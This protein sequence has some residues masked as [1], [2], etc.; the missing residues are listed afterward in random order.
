MKLSEE[1]VA[2][3]VVACR[4]TGSMRGKTCATVVFRDKN[5]NRSSHFETHTRKVCEGF[6]LGKGKA[7]G[8][9]SFD[10]VP[11][12]WQWEAVFGCWERSSCAE[13]TELN[14]WHICVFAYISSHIS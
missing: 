1:A 2:G 7:R 13:L 6:K 12:L 3:F 5:V 4:K 14:Y 10:D 11:S 8:D 9:G